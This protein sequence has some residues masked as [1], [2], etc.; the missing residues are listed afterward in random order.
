MVTHDD[1]KAIPQ[2][3]CE[4]HRRLSVRSLTESSPASTAPECTSTS[5]PTRPQPP[6][7]IILGLWPY[8]TD[9]QIGYYV[10]GYQA[11]YPSARL[12]LLHYSTSYDKCIGNA[13]NSLT[14]LDEKDSFETAPNVLLHLFSG[15]GAAQGC[16]LLRAYKIRTQRRLPVKAVIMDSVPRL[17]TPSMRAV[18]DTPRLWLEFV[19]MLM[20]VV[21]IRLL[22]TVYYWKFE[23]RTQQNR[24]DLLDDSLLPAEARKCFIFSERDLMF[25]WHDRPTD[26]EEEC[27]RDDIAVKRS[28]IDDEQGRWTSDQERY[29]YG[30][31]NVWEGR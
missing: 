29:W 14:A 26:G 21:Y 12:L 18:R 6:Q 30:I 20:T 17:P 23:H 11:L 5:T 27:E 4:L 3:D 24:R 28:S 25:S 31:E 19:Y 2:L 22:S 1:E 15:C 7:T 13:L 8:A 10:E 16:R 9:Y